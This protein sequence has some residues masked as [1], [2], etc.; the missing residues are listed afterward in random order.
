[1]TY[2]PLVPQGNQTIASTTDPIRNN[3]VFLQGAVGEEHNFNLA[4]A[5]KTYHLQAS[6][7]NLGIA[8]ALPSGTN[9]MYYVESGN[10][11]F[12]DGTTISRLTEGI[13]SASGYQWIG[14]VLLQWGSVAQGTSYPS[15]ITFPIDFPTAV[16]NVQISANYDHSSTA[17]SSFGIY[18]LKSGSTPTLTQFTIR[19]DVG[20]TPYGF[21]WLA[22]GN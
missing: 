7:P 2:T 17:G 15:T 10:A 16:F 14:K 3:F 4:D 12:W 8:P 1:M 19:Q 6:M 18:I 11:R 13:A 9:G 21:Y 20:S 22:I 5:T